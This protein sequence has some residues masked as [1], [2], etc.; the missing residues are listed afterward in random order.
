MS[1]DKNATP[2]IYLGGDKI[3]WLIREGG[4]NQ[5]KAGV[6]LRKSRKSEYNF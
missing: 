5:Q 1:S 2:V 4:K 3:V 6:C